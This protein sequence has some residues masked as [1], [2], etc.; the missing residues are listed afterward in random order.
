MGQLKRIKARG[1]TPIGQN[2]RK[3]WSPFEM[4]RAFRIHQSRLEASIS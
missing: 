4:D 3:I 2:P 1:Y